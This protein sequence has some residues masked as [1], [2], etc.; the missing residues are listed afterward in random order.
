[1]RATRRRLQ[2]QPLVYG[3]RHFPWHERRHVRAARVAVAFVLAT[4]L[5]MTSGGGAVAYAVYAYYD[6]QLPAV[7]LIFSQP[8]PQST[9]VYDRNGNLLDE[10]YDPN[11]GHRIVVSLAE[12]SPLL[13][14]ATLAAEDPNFYTEPGFDPVAIGRAVLLNLQ[15]GGI[16]SGASTLPMQLV[17]NVVF[18]AQE[19]QDRSYSRKIKEIIVSTQLASQYPK[20]K[21]LE[22]YLNE[23][24]YGNQ[25]YGVEAASR[26]YFAKSAKDLNLAEAALL[27]GL[28]QAP[29]DYDPYKNPELATQRQTYVLDQMVKYGFITEAEA[30]QAKS[31]PIYLDAERTH[32]D[33]APHFAL[34]V[35]QLLIDRFGHDQVYYGGLRV[36]TS[37]DLQKQGFATQRV[38]ERLSQLKDVHATDAALVSIDPHTG[39]V[40]AMVGSPNFYD[41]SISGQIN[42]A[43]SPRQPGSS[44][45]PFNYITAFEKLG[46][47]PASLVNDAPTCFP[48]PPGAPPYCPHNWNYLFNGV[49]P[50]R[51]ALASSLNIPAVMLLSNEGVPAMLDTVHKFGITTINKPAKDYGLALTLGAAEV[52]LLDETFAYTVFA[53][54][55]Q[56]IGAKVPRDQLKPGYAPCEPV[57]LKKVVDH[58]GKVLYEHTPQ[59]PLQV[60]PA[61]YAYLITAA[62]SDDTSRVLT[63]GRHSYLE[64]SHPNAAK[65][66]TTEYRGD[67][68]TMGY[69]TDLVTGVWVGNADN[70]PMLNVEGVSAAGVIWHNYMEDAIKDMPIR[71]FPMPSK[72]R[73][74]Q[75][76]GRQDVYIEG[77]TPVCSVYLLPTEPAATPTANPSSGN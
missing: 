71:E 26:T 28:P 23:V 47:V 56:M 3:E 46:Y 49:V 6:S 24:F 48:R 12:M 20:D 72:I 64:L 74:G 30:E 18:T 33:E 2:H 50:L 17:R 21:I 8:V 52:K 58:T 59:P 44:I 68:W 4:A 32:F 40:L 76:C 15:H 36:T 65:T 11:V 57:I 55:G 67:A 22:M 31:T 19:R 5:L 41:N 34:Y 53:N 63:Y 51:V 66:G 61:E 13:R 16:V 1:M 45:K 9:L 38:Q 35:R 60:V 27:A 43:V 10:I 25:S 42:M 39:E 77:K 7:G 54:N 14:E 69:T 37:L 70:T 62:I 75:V 73:Q 29:S